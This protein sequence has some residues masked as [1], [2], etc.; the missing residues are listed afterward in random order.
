M[1]CMVDFDSFLTP[2]H[3]Q[4]VLV[5]IRYGFITSATANPFPGVLPGCFSSGIAKFQSVIISG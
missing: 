1:R 2:G 4:G 3:S 5:S